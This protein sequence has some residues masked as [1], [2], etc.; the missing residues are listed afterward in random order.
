MPRTTIR[1]SCPRVGRSGGNGAVDLEI[2]KR[3]F[4]AVALAAE[5]LVVANLVYAI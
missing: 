4:D 3:A 1:G 5:A 2:T